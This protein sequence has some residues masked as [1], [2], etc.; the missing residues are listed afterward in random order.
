MEDSMN[1]EISLIEL[2]NIFKKNTHIIIQSVVVCVAAAAIITVFFMTPKYQAATQMLVN[3]TANDDSINVG[4]IQTSVQMITTYKEIIMGDTVLEPVVE[5]LNDG[6][7]VSSLSDMV[8]VSNTQNS[9]VFTIAVTSDDPTFSAT[10]ANLLAVTFQKRIQEIFKIDNVTVVSE[11]TDTP[12]KVSPSLTKNIL[13]AFV[14]GV[15]IAVAIIIIK[16]MLDTRVHSE[17][18]LQKAGFTILGTVNEMTPSE[19]NHTRFKRKAV[20][21]SNDST[22]SVPRRRRV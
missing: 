14:L 5:Q 8:N 19:L 9:Q 16:Q 21:P 11:A 4:E 15:G 18:D 6:T 1:E 22:D 17:D 13:I 2:F 12:R 10:A 3:Q 7:T 20:K